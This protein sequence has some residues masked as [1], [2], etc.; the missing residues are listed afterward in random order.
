MHDY[1]RVEIEVQRPFSG[2]ASL[3]LW[4]SSL[5]CRTLT[6]AQEAAGAYARRRGGGVSALQRSE[7]FVFV[8][9]YF[10]YFALANYATLEKGPREKRK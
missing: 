3:R 8:V 1:C 6:A 7:R 5:L 4:E 9:A 10:A 2:C